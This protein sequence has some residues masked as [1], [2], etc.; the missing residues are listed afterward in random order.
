MRTTPPLTLVVDGDAAARTLACSVIERQLGW[1]TR[2]A[3][4]AAAALAALADLTATTVL[5]GQ[6]MTDGTAVEL[7][8]RIRQSYA[9]V[10]VLLLI[11]AGGEKLGL[12]ALRR[13]AASY[14]PKA[15]LE[16]ELAASLE[17]IAAAAQAAHCRRRIQS[18]LR[19]VELEF[20]IEND[21]AL[22]P[23]LVQHLQEHLRAMRMCDQTALIRIG[24]ALEE[25]LVNGMYHGNLE[26]SSSLRQVDENQF[27]RLIEE[28]RQL[29][30]YRDRPLTVGAQISPTV[31]TFVVSDG[32]A[33]FDPKS[34]PDPTDPVNLETVGGRG[35]LLIRTFMDEVQFNT[36]GNQITMVKR[37]GS[38]VADSR[39]AVG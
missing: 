38:A 11:D 8:D 28:R 20:V 10:P 34:L 15:E 23:A 27:E 2:E 29:T 5:T 31:A 19:R 26:V 32:G 6:R 37:C 14:I 39:S 18:A 35:L 25:A 16:T 7:V 30:P 9:G 12:E 36:T 4:S 33:G 21:P 1:R 24:V 22:V 13:G 3:D 17:Q